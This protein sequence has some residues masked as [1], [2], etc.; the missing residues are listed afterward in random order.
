MLTQVIYIT[1]VGILSICTWALPDASNEIDDVTP[2]FLFIVIHH[3]RSQS[4]IICCNMEKEKYLNLWAQEL[5]FILSAIRNGGGEKALSGE[6]FQL[7]GNRTKSGYSFRLD[8]NNGTIPTKSNTAVAR[9]LKK[10][11]DSSIEFRS[12]PQN[13]QIT[14]R[15]GV[16]F[17]L[18][19]E[20]INNYRDS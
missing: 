4:G 10:V 13:K 19:I 9:D 11:L 17:I 3:E 2:H 7:N 16:K 14:I 8:I 20:I 12:I 1:S 15:M 18:T 5:P 6:K